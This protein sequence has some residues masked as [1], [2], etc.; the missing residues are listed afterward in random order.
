MSITSHVLLVDAGFGLPS[1]LAVILDA[2]CRVQAVDRFRMAGRAFD[3][4]APD[5]LIFDV[6]VPD[7][8]GGGFIESV[9]TRYPACRVVVVGGVADGTRLH[10]LSPF[11][12]DGAFRRGAEFGAVLSRVVRLLSLQVKWRAAELPFS[13][14]V[15]RAMEHV[16]AG[17]HQSLTLEGAARAARIS[18]SHLAHLFPDFTG[19]TFKQYV[20]RVRVEI[21]KRLLRTTDAGLDAIA[22]QCGFCD[23]P[24]LSRVFRRRTGLRPGAY[25]RAVI[26]APDSEP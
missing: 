24:H 17:Y 14:Y 3:R 11:A 12:L 9:K 5:L 20:A 16:A 19:F 22:E 8:D 2:Y 4:V 10:R 25:R 21:A 18:S 6:G 15:S 1:M 26:L 13:P 23:A 7:L